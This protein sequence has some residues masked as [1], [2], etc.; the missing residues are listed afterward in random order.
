[1]KNTVLKILCEIQT[2]KNSEMHFLFT[3]YLEKSNFLTILD[4]FKN[5]SKITFVKWWFTHHIACYIISYWINT[6]RPEL[7]KKNCGLFRYFYPKNFL[8]YQIS[9][10]FFFVYFFLFHLAVFFIIHISWKFFLYF[11]KTEFFVFSGDIFF[12]IFFV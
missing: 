2:L 1:M 11:E 4:N 9:P 6:T 3:R 12:Y 10:N 8:N 7:Q 5:H